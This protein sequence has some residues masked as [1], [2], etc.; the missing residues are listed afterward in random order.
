HV[1]AHSPQSNHGK[2]HCSDSGK[3]QCEKFFEVGAQLWC[4]LV[5][6]DVHPHRF[7]RCQILLTV[8]D[9]KRVRRLAL[10][11]AEC[12]I[13]EPT[14]RLSHA[15]PAG[16]DER[17]EYRRQPELPDPVIVELFGF[18]VERHHPKAGRLR[19]RARDSYGFRVSHALIEH[20][21]D[22]CTAC[23]LSLGMKDGDVQILVERNSSLFPFPDDVLVS[24][25]KIV[26][27]EMEMFDGA[28]ALFAIPTV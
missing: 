25:L 23:K 19:Q 16:G 21:A 12:A 28:I 3:F 17:V 13:V 9:E 5:E 1:A 7:R 10:G 20:E 27:V 15:Q 14:K 18:V 8:I 11:D 26:S 22:E 24:P 2:T 4:R 6:Y